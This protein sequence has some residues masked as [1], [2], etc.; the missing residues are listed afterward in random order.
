MSYWIASPPDC[1]TAGECKFRP[2]CTA[3]DPDCSHWEYALPFDGLEVPYWP[4]EDDALRCAPSETED[5]SH[6]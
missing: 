1:R 5:A 4:Q 3:A 2:D 6:V